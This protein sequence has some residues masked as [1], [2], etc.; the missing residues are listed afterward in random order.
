MLAATDLIPLAAGSPPR[1]RDVAR[2]WGENAVESMVDWA[3]PLGLS[4][5]PNR[6]HSPTKQP[7]SPVE[8]ANVD[9]IHTPGTRER[10]EY[11]HGMLKSG[12]GALSALAR[13]L[14]VSL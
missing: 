11:L 7:A 9:P 3:F 12:G 14:S 4:G 10:S 5:S 1:K 8:W 13:L 6:Q 2:Q